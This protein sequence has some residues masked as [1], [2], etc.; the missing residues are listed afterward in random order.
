MPARQQGCLTVLG[1]F[2]C[3]ATLSAPSGRGSENALVYLQP[4]TEPRPKGAVETAGTSPERLSTLASRTACPTCIT[5]LFEEAGCT[6]IT[7]ITPRPR[8]SACCSRWW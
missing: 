5:L 3:T 6:T 1:D 4:L 2:V 7:I 8:E